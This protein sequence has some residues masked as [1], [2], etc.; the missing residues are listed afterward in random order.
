MCF[1][2]FILNSVSKRTPIFCVF[3]VFDVC[4]GFLL[5]G[6]AQEAAGGAGEEQHAERRAEHR[7]AAGS[8]QQLWGLGSGA[9]RS[10]FCPGITA[11][12]WRHRE[13]IVVCVFRKEIPVSSD[14]AQRSMLFTEPVKLKVAADHFWG[15]K[16]S[17]VILKDEVY[18]AV[19][20]IFLSVQ[21]SILM[22]LKY[23]NAH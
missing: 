4:S 11:D 18:S 1:L 5:L 15:I 7:A 14:L 20:L 10:L 12:Q 23:I 8:A 17:S 22:Y 13:A 9:G 2:T 3:V 6:L 21:K 16:C 19:L